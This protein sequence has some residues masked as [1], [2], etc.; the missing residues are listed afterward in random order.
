MV[1]E[2]VLVGYVI[3]GHQMLLGYIFQ[4]LLGSLRR[5]IFSN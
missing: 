1:S 3:G 4:C 5:E 2:G